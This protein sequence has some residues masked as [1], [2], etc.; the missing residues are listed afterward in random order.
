MVDILVVMKF[1]KKNGVKVFVV[2]NVVG[3][4]VMRIVDLIFYMYV[5]LEIG[6]V[7]IKIYMI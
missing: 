6:V 5:G 1:V 3:S 7:V 2:V 4:M